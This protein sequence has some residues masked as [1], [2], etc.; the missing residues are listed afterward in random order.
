MSAEVRTGKTVEEQHAEVERLHE[1][2]G[3][4]LQELTSAQGAVPADED[5]VLP[6]QPQQPAAHPDP[7]P[8]RDPVA[9]YR[10]WP[11]SPRL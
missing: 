10:Q 7:T 3:T 11:R 2:I 9:G 4:Q 1:Q 8:G 6:L 5:R